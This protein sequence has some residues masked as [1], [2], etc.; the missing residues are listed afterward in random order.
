MYKELESI[1]KK[2][3]RIPDG[4]I[5]ADELSMQ[6]C[7]EWDSLAQMMIIVDLQKHFNVKFDY[8]EVLSM[9]SL[10]EIKRVLTNKLGDV[11]VL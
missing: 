5:L 1:I 10:A 7:S 11:D 9:S 4:E 3:L 2:H 8:S 6:T